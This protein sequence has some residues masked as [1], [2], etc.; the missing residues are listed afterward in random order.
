MNVSGKVNLLATGFT[1]QFTYLMAPEPLEVIRIFNDVRS[2]EQSALDDTSEVSQVKQVVRLGWGG[3]QI[4][5][6]VLVHF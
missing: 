5:H 4:C 3:Q 6:G 1:G 2:G